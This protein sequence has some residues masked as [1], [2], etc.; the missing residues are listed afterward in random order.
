MIKK[1]LIAT[2][3]LAGALTSA[4]WEINTENLSLEFSNPTDG[5]HLQAITNRQNGQTFYR[6][7]Q[8]NTPWWSVGLT[9]P[10]D[11]QTILTINNFT[12][13]IRN[14]SNPKSGQWL[15]HYDFQLP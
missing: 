11:Q 10:G 9:V 14:V 5:L 12:D 15:L 1:S 2:L 4:A 3:F 6:N 7:D 13:G 8:S